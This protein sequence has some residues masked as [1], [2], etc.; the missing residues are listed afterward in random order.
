MIGNLIGLVVL[1]ALAVFFAW[2]TRRAW[3]SKRGPIK[4]V[5]VVLAGLPTLLLGLLSVFAAVGMGKIYTPRGSP[6]SDITVAGTAE[7]IARRAPGLRFLR[8]LP[9]TR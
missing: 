3:R 9:L 7:Q 2:L 5:G 1:I 6:A 4:W 8:D